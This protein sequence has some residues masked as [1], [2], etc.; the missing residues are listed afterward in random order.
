[1]QI[2]DRVRLIGIP[3]DVADDAEFRTLTLFKN[4]LGKVFAIRGF[5]KVEGL[6][7]CLVQ[8]DVGH[9]VGKEDYMESIYVEPEYVEVLE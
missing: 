4:C 1:M 7:Y 2:G 8:L 6:P 3:P 9:L 5:Q